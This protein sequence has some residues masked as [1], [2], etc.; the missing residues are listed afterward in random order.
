MRIRAFHIDAFGV[1]SQV[2]VDDLPRG[3]G[4]FLG[5]N[6]AGKSTCLEFFRTV[7]T[8]YPAPRTKESRKSWASGGQ[9]QG[10]SLHLETEDGAILRLSRRPGPAGGV[11]ALFDAVGNPVDMAELDR[12]MGGV[13]REVYRSIYG[14]S[15][16]ELQSF[17]S[18]D[19]EAVRNALYG[20]SFGLGLR[21]PGAALAR[22]ENAMDEV[23]KPR[24]K[25]GTLNV[26][27]RRWEEVR[28]EL[29]EA[30]EEAAR[31]DALAS[32]REEAGE[33]LAALRAEKTAL[34]GERRDLERRL[35]V[36]KQ[37]E[38]WRL[39]QAR[40]ERLEPVA[41]TFPL[42]G[43]ARLERLLDRREEARRRAA[44]A[45]E[46]AERLTATLA[47][48]T[49]DVRLLPLAPDIRALSER[50]SSCRNALIA[51]PALRAN[52]QRAEENLARQLALL[53][54]DWDMERIRRMDR[55]LFVREELERR[56]MAIQAA[57]TG[58]AALSSALE[59]AVRD[60]EQA[61]HGVELARQAL[62]ALPEPVAELD[63]PARDTLRAGLLRVEEGERRL[64]ERE[65]ALAAS[66]AE[67]GRALSYLRLRPDASPAQLQALAAAQEEALGL[68]EDVR[69]RAAV[70]AD[71]SREVQTA[72]KDEEAAADRLNRLL[73]QEAEL[74]GADR[75]ALDKRRAALRRLRQSAALLHQEE[76]R[77]ADLGE[78]HAAQEAAFPRPR[79]NRP[80]LAAGSVLSAI[81][82]AMLIA[83]LGLGVETIDIPALWTSLLSS[84]V[85]AWAG[86][87]SLPLWAAYVVLFV[88]VVCLAVGLPRSGPDRERC[89][90]QLEQLRSRRDTSAARL[91]ELQGEVRALCEGL[92]LN[93]DALQAEAPDALD[94]LD[95][96]LDQ[97][98]EQCA[99]GERIQQEKTLLQSELDA[100]RRW[101][102]QRE[103]EH[104]AAESAVQDVQRRWHDYLVRLGVLNVPVPE[105]AQ[106]FFARV[107]ST[108][109]ARAAAASIE[110]EIRELRGRGPELVATA[111]E[112]LPSGAL[113]PPPPV[114]A[115]DSLA[116]DE[117]EAVTA[118]VRRVLESCRQ[119]DARSEKRA[120]AAE[121]LRA[122]EATAVRAGEAC[123]AA[124][125][126]LREGRAER[127]A[128]DAEWREYLGGLGLDL[129]LSPS[130][131]REA[132]DCMERCLAAETE[133]TRLREETALQERERDALALPLADLL[134]R[135]GR[136]PHLG[137]DR[138]PD[139]LATLDIMQ[140]DADNARRVDEERA[141]VL[142]QA[143]EQAEE[144]R[145]AEAAEADACRAVDEL[146]GLGRADDPESFRRLAAVRDER[147]GLLRRC[148]DLEDALRLAA[149]DIP[150][151]SFLEEFAA[152]DKGSLDVRSAEVGHR[153]EEL[154]EDE[155]R[156]AAAAAALDARL[157][158][159]TASRRL[160]DLRARDASLE[161]SARLLSREW[162]RLALARELLLDARRHYE[163]E[164]QPE[165]IR[166]ASDIFASI[167]DGAWP[168]V[169]ASLE[170]SSLRVVPPHGD[171]L[172]PDVL[173]RGAQ[174]QL[175]LALRLAHIR[176]HARH[177]AALPVIM[178]DILVNFDPDRARRTM[179][180]LAD[181]TAP[182]DGGPG[183]QIL[184]FT[185]HPGMA[186]QLRELV[187]DSALFSVDKGRIARV[188]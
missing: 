113:P 48:L 174:E 187:P 90:S 66:R 40:L 99:A 82:A 32:E 109:L 173:S 12:L 92:G 60:G 150:L 158:D 103:R 108:R 81:G 62:E 120:A 20:A 110:E 143:E 124:E 45:R 169:S 177:A 42:D 4:I 58:V 17:E 31:Y 25:T 67:Y 57:D 146:L 166:T 138:E 164:R 111:R 134:E 85:P 98:R 171:P 123:A 151:A 71:A 160:A 86:V 144:L 56:A 176:S 101:L 114:S 157:S 141:R 127:A 89:E 137:L 52:L 38:E 18:L 170:D 168:L 59:R 8:G 65:K 28:V 22:L 68:A 126:A 15:L 21:S 154:R 6:E 172:P 51:L 75:Q 3:M 2:T 104:A 78:R 34:E 19:S 97:E 188:G 83:R 115:G 63:A 167:T 119:A 184:F 84:P 37:W 94:A 27:L 112:I 93:P 106:A 156:R 116:A 36:W 44:I 39:A 49:P 13:T 24:G 131:T 128:L 159:M 149:G 41:E 33:A 26:A 135:A 73:T 1:L 30:E 136:A 53:G 105:A 186:E 129:H 7:L 107:E 80:A 29:R 70:A 50:K 91:A 72:R 145:A 9:N 96:Q 142:A 162:S 14:F 95:A 178:D 182:A 185:C 69:S 79:A 100:K 5:N 11:P 88:G 74:S 43:P 125:S 139:W 10:G 61:E 183:H 165:V 35:G 87:A 16:S 163:K 76:E 122:A 55:S 130:T 153:L 140:R 148:Q 161:E 23:F 175:Y 133:C 117:L 180:A 47:D 118:A 77:L 132:L 64:P 155:Q 121:A 147:D 54:P 152:L 102:Q 181:L 179:R 46:R